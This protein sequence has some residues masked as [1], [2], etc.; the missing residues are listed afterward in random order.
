MGYH[1]F[2]EELL[3]TSF[4]FKDGLVQP[5]TWVLRHNNP[6]VL[7]E[8]WHGTTARAYGV[9]YVPKSYLVDSEGCILQK[10]IVLEDLKKVVISRF[11]S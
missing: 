6:E 4:V 7:I 10:D 1:H 9:Q 5:L 2:E 11:G 3:S 8:G